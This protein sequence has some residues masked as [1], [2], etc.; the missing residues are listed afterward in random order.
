MC[1][2]PKLFCGKNENERG[3]KS[4]G[5][6]SSYFSKIKKN[7]KNFFFFNDQ[8]TQK[9]NSSPMFSEVSLEYV[10]FVLQLLCLLCFLKKARRKKD[11]D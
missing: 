5:S 11:E 7:V 6:F 10:P 2:F 9:K 8:Q 1:D 3:K 4:D